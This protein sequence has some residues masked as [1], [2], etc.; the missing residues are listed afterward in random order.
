MSIQAL[1]FHAEENGASTI[2]AA[3]GHQEALPALAYGVIALCILMAL[4]LIT[5]AFRN[6]GARH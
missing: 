5:F 1:V 4:L 2:N 6:M 3:A